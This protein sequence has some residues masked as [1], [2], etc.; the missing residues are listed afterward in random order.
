MY[1]LLLHKIKYYKAKLL[2]VQILEPIKNIINPSETEKEIILERRRFEYYKN[3]KE[4]M[5]CY[6]IIRII[7]KKMQKKSLIELVLL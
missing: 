6:S 1:I 5:N 2:I 7:Q 4:K 3:K